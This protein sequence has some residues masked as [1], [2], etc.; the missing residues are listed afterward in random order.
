[1]SKDV[2]EFEK[3]RYCSAWNSNKGE[4]FLGGKDGVCDDNLNTQKYSNFHLNPYSAI[5]KAKEYN[6]TVTDVLNLV[7]ACD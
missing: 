5:I 1:M 2:R 7:E 6:I 4:C 3:C